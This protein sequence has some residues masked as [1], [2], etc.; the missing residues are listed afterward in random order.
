MTGGAVLIGPS[1]HPCTDDLHVCL[2]NIA[3]IWFILSLRTGD[4]FFADAVG[5]GHLNPVR[6]IH[7]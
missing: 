3:E 2:F 5:K 6:A 4:R 1:V 7:I